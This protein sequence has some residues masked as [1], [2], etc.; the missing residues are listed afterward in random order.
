MGAEED[1]CAEA[2]KLQRIDEAFVAG[3]LDALRG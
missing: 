3:D 1:R 2:K